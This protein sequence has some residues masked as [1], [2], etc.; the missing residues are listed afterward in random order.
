MGIHP[1]ELAKDNDGLA[2]R[3][4]LHINIDQGRNGIRRTDQENLHENLQNISY[5][6]K[7]FSFVFSHTLFWEYVC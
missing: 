2:D 7:S 5:K 1:T 4:I 6:I 3:E